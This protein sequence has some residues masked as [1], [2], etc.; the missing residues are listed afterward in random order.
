MRE[1]ISLAFIFLLSFLLVVTLAIIIIPLIIYAPLIYLGSAIIMYD[2]LVRPLS[3]IFTP[4]G[5]ILLLI[6][7]I[8]GIYSFILKKPN[9]R[10]AT[11][12]LPGIGA[13]LA[14]MEYAKRGEGEFLKFH[15][16]QGMILFVVTSIIFLASL[17]LINL[18]RLALAY[19]T[20]SV[21]FVVGPLL[22]IYMMYTTYK[23]E[24]VTLI[25]L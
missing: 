4:A 21:V 13:V 15:A 8:I 19:Y 1:R 7:I 17:V 3:D 6:V 5:A 20:L 12:Y 10:A 22:L 23:E 11:F 18:E 16:V 25:R 9:A 24:K 2:N 14:V